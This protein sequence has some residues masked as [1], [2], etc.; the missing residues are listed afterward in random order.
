MDHLQQN[1]AKK[2]MASALPHTTLSYKLEKKV[3]EFLEDNTA[4]VK[5]TIRSFSNEIE[6]ESVRYM[7]RVIIA[8]QAIGG[9]DVAFF[10]LY[11]HEQTLHRA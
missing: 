5:I 4:G 1:K 6:K 9:E 3:N 10:I 2:L 7:E 8:F 11:A